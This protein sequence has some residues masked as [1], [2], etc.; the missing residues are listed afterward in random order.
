MKMKK[1]VLL[2]LMI[3]VSLAAGKIRVIAT[4]FPVYDLS[5]QVGG[6]LCEVSM[7]IP[8]GTESHSYEPT[9]GQITGLGKCDLLVYT[10]PYMEPWIEKA[11]RGAGVEPGSLVNSCKNIEFLGGDSDDPGGK[12]P[13]AWLDPMN[14][15]RMAGNIAAAFERKDPANAEKYRRNAKAY[16]SSLHEFVALAKTTVS[17]FSKK[18]FFFAGHFAYGYFVKRYGL[19]YD[20]PFKGFSPD[21]EPTPKA[22]ARMSDG[23]KKAGA[24]VIYREELLSSR[25]ADALASSGGLTVLELSAAHNITKK[26]QSGGVTLLAIFQRNLNNLER[27]LK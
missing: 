11:A 4:I 7:L 19:T 22:L 25:L 24:T 5:R 26:E 1:L 21:A 13:H 18:K 14:A 8:P 16:I 2:L 10:N 15:A 23:I 3:T 12:D 17:G 6:G 9:P 27:G 20:S